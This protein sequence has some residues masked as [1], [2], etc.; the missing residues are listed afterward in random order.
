[1]KRWL[2]VIAWSAVILATSNDWFSAAH[3]GS[4]L[5][6]SETVNVIFRKLMHLTGYGILGVLA[7]SAA[8]QQFG[9]PASSPADRETSRFPRRR[10]AAG[11]AAG[12]A[13]F[14]IVILVA[15]IDELNQSFVPSR[16]GSPWDVLLD[17]VG[18][19]IAIAILR[20][21]EYRSR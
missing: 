12:T 8:R 19:T 18:A 2:P 9:T 4:W 14:L 20:V 17:V 21:K 16:G 15:S 7:W 1:M 6:V 3:T 5:G 13:A 11:P 10:D